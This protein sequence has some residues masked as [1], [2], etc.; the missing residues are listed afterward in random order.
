M[1]LDILLADHDPAL[2]LEL[3][4]VLSASGHL[5]TLAA[6]REQAAARLDDH[7][8]DLVICDLALPDVGG[9]ALFR[10]VRRES[11]QT[12]VVLI[13]AHG[14]VQDAVQALKE[15][16][17][18]YLTKPIE[19]ARLVH[20]LERIAKYRA[21][22][23]E[24]R[25]LRALTD[26]PPS[27][28]PMLGRSAAMVR[29][30]ERV[31]I[32]AESEAPVLIL[33]ESGTGKELVARRLHDGSRRRKGRFVAVNC[34][35]FPETLIEAEL[36]GHER[37][38]FTGAVRRRDGRFKVADGGTLFLDEVAEVPLA[39]QAK[40]LRV[41]QDG[42]FEPIGS[43]DPIQVD[44][45]VISATHRTLRER[46]TSGRFREDLYYRLKV[47]DLRLPPLRD[48]PGDLPVLIQHFI[49]RYS[50]EGR[51][52]GLSPRAWAALSAYAFPG[53]VRELEH[54]I[55][56][57]VVLARDGEI[58]LWH[59]PSDISGLD[60]PEDERPEEVRPLA[61]ALRGFEREYLLRALSRAGG[62]KKR[63]AELLGI[64]RKNLWEKLRAHGLSEPRSVRPAPHE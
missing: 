29:L 6:D 14:T 10:R 54:A 61:Q 32:I 56:H 26:V 18:D 1:R 46:V 47:I 5:V 49:Q 12:D 11:P 41:L 9:F 4:E 64:S 2:R 53:N 43:N 60:E 59:L 28:V 42:C 15:G 57:G 30:F 31:D 38:A 34:A 3:S 33:G 7:V 24:L 8:Y 62:N 16:A 63:T 13:S 55:H 50:P 44:V 45:R 17:T 35:A 21:L 40:L 27:A 58:D 37:G 48:R 39:A 19:V 36:F 20:E 51:I 52:N 25:R 23:R 22:R